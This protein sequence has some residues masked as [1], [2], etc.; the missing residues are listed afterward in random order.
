MYE[1]EPGR[2]AGFRCMSEC[3][4]VRGGAVVVLMMI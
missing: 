2:G 4:W 1:R 3:E